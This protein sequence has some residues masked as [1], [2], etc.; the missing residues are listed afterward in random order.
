MFLNTY[1]FYDN[2]PELAHH[3]ADSNHCENEKLDHGEDC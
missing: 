1:Q 2:V 3:S